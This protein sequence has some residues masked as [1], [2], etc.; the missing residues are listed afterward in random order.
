ME[1]HFIAT[2]IGYV[3][4]DDTLF[5]I[6][7]RKEHD[8]DHARGI[9]SA[10]LSVEAGAVTATPPEHVPAMIRVLVLKAASSAAPADLAGKSDHYHTVHDARQK[11][12]SAFSQTGF[13][14]VHRRPDTTNS[15]LPSSASDLPKL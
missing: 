4:K 13:G 9:A 5:V 14:A 12:Q 10:S 1:T 11:A 2:P 6:T 8:L 3:V 15:K 7:G